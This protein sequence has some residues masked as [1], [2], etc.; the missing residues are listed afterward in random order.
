M[1]ATI[2]IK[3]HRLAHILI[4]VSFLYCC[5]MLC[6]F[7]IYEKYSVL[8]CN[9]RG[10]KMSLYYIIWSKM[11]LALDTVYQSNQPTESRGS[12]TDYGLP[13]ESKNIIKVSNQ[14]PPPPTHTHTHIRTHN[15]S[16]DNQWIDINIIT[17]SERTVAK[18]DGE[19]TI[20][21]WPTV[22]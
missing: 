15:G 6:F 8:Q 2:T 18:A 21:Y 17:T 5:F 3:D 22:G 7:N 1:N 16:N 11:K 14:T 9:E 20:F 4:K 10:L 19:L 13:Q 12:D